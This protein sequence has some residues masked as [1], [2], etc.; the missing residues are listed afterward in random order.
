MSKPWRHKALCRGPPAEDVLPALCFNACPVRK[1]C[2]KEALEESDW[3]RG[4][5]YEPYHV[6]GG[7]PA[8]TR[9]AVMR[10]T[11]FRARQA[12]NLLI[13]REKNGSQN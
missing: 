13:E 4:V 7:Y 8:A 5:T 1:D 10:E 9:F 11:G 12:F 2:L 6:W 3:H